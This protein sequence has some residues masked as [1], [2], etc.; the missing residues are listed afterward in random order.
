MGT[1]TSSIVAVGLVGTGLGLLIGTLVAPASGRETR[2]R[3][4][5]RVEDEVHGLRRR[6]RRTVEDAVQT[7]V[8]YAAEHL[9]H[10]REAV[11]GLVRD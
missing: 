6:G 5:R 9:Q 7:G 3:W 2:R 4:R 11:A 8:D 10:G 1:R